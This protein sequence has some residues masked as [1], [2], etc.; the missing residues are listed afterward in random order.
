M[1]ISGLHCLKDA[2]NMIVWL[3]LKDP[4]LDPRI[5]LSLSL[6]LCLTFVCVRAHTFSVH[7]SQ[8]RPLFGGV[9]K[10]SGDSSGDSL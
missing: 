3:T 9:V 10:V 4:V 2:Q 1:C 8:P 5:D 7:K 6:S